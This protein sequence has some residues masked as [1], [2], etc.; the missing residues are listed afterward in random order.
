M[1]SRSMTKH[2]VAKLAGTIFLLCVASIGIFQVNELQGSVA[3]LVVGGLMVVSG[4]TAVGIWA[5]GLPRRQDVYAVD[6]EA[7]SDR[8]FDGGVDEEYAYSGG[9][10]RM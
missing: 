1:Y 5:N 8:P 7:A 10:G 4:F 6:Q 9:A 2:G 3:S